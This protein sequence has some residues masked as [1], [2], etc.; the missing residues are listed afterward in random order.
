MQGGHALFLGAIEKPFDL[1]KVLLYL[2][3]AVQP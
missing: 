2:P 1:D 3:E